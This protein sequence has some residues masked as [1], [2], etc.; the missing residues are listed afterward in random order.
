MTRRILL[1]FLCVLILSSGLR[2]GF[3]EDDGKKRVFLIGNS[4]TWDTVPS[5]LDGNVQWHVDCGKSLPFMFANPE[6]PCVKTSTLWPKALK[7]NQY[8]ILSLQTHYGATLAED[9]ET[10]S[11]WIEMQPQAVVVIH[12]GWAHRRGLCFRG[13]RRRDPEVFS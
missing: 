6:E 7:E 9:V 12:T 2:S 11:R 10:I 8:D 4:L 1:T 3:G 13:G 5:R